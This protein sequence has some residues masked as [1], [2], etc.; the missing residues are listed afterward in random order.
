VP[1]PDAARVRADFD[2]IARLGPPRDVDRVTRALLEDLGPPR[3][4][5]DV[6]CGGGALCRWLAER[7]VDVVGVDL[8]PQM[9]VQARRADARGRARYVEADLFGYT[10][11][12]PFDLV[13][14]VATLHHAPLGPALDRLR[15]WVAPGGALVVHD[16][17]RSTAPWERAVDAVAALAELPRGLVRFR[18][19]DLRRAWRRHGAH[20]VYPSLGEVRA[21]VARHVPGARVR[22]HLRWRYSL[23]WRAPAP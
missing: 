20:D 10:P 14:S 13:V 21:A 5:L 11:D 18:D 17:V 23:V 2:R 4:A 1:H 22:R 19:D 15:R 6:G 12:A 16:L 9:L 8:S 7:G 3:T